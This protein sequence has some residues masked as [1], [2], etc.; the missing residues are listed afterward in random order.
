MTTTNI[1]LT[2]IAVLLAV[3]IVWLI[4]HKRNNPPKY[5]LGDRVRFVDRQLIGF[6]YVNV[7]KIWRVYKHWFCEPS[8]EIFEKVLSG[9]CNYD[10]SESNIIE[11][12]ERTNETPSNPLEPKNK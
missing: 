2:L 11:L 8:Y 9:G 3:R 5:Q 4:R 7:G 1:L 6:D 10:I 12:I